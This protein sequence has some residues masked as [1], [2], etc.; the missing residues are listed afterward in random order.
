MLHVVISVGKN[1]FGKID[2]QFDVL[3]FV[4]SRRVATSSQSFFLSVNISCSHVQTEEFSFCVS[5]SEFYLAMIDLFQRYDQF[6][7]LY[8]L[9]QDRL[10]VT[11]ELF[12]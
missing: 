11:E 4:D 7:K 1:S 9:R 5:D 3:V 6:I 10:E 2:D 12:P 8:F